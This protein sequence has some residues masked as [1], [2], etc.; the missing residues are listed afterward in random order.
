MLD[1]KYTILIILAV[2][3]IGLG[4]AAYSLTKENF[5][6]GAP[7]TQNT[8]DLQVTEDIVLQASEGTDEFGNILGID[9]TFTNFVEGINYV[10][11]FIN[12]NTQSL[13][14]Q[15]I[16]AD[17]MVNV[18]DFG[19]EITVYSIV[20]DTLSVVNSMTGEPITLSS[21]EQLGTNYLPLFTIRL[22]DETQ[23]QVDNVQEE[24]SQPQVDNVQEESQPQVDNVQEEPQPQVDN[25]QEEPQPQVEEAVVTTQ[26]PIVPRN[27]LKIKFN[28]NV[29]LTKD[30]FL[31]NKNSIETEMNKLFIANKFVAPGQYSLEIY[32]GSIYVL[33]KYY[34]LNNT[35]V[36]ALS[37][38]I[39][40]EKENLKIEMNIYD[41][42]NVITKKV[43]AA[44]DNS[45]ATEII[46]QKKR[47][48]I[49]KEY[50]AQTRNVLNSVNNNANLRYAATT[51]ISPSMNNNL[52]ELITNALES[53]NNNTVETT[54]PPIQTNLVEP[55][56]PKMVNN[57]EQIVKEEKNDLVVPENAHVV[58]SY[59]NLQNTIKDVMDGVPPSYNYNKNNLNA[60]MQ[61]PMFVESEIM[62]DN[63]V[64]VVNSVNNKEIVTEEVMPANVD[65]NLPMASEVSTAY[66]LNEVSTIPKFE[67]RYNSE[68]ILPYNIPIIPTME[69]EIPQVPNQEKPLQKL[70]MNYYPGSQYSKEEQAKLIAD[71]EK[72]MGTQYKVKAFDEISL[73]KSCDK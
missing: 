30:E 47:D 69:Q 57:V 73:G 3:L 34:E 16:N 19:N 37:K 8:I 53:V 40:D 58:S 59:N 17:S 21:V 45:T 11:V 18:I 64:V 12:P 36:Q 52:K 42:N 62:T 68:N 20:N 28:T 15:S 44:K 41:E 10:I 67:Q 56:E 23:P 35:E 31:L 32:P 7:I 13:E 55:E 71:I 43:R 63:K 29:T 5:V 61:S 26:S 27:I 1:M 66:T 25:V 4:Y 24:E 22:S 38:K 60:V 9:Y 70:Y 50:I 48:E 49:F 33:I 54:M 72:K 46:E 14:I 6:G 39:N 51:T 2:L 65:T